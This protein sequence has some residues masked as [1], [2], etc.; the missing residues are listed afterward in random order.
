[1]VDDNHKI[2]PEL[3]DELEALMQAA[4]PGPWKFAAK[5]E[6]FGKGLSIIGSAET[7]R[8]WDNEVMDDGTGGGEYSATTTLNT[9]EFII[10]S[11]NALPALIKEVRRLQQLEKDR[12]EYKPRNGI[13]K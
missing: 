3:L 12:E 5:K 1:M 7:D 11:R 2:T 8:L 6:H 4:H 10:A 13:E 9:M